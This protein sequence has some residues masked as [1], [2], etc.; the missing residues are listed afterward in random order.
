MSDLDRIRTL[1][2]EL[3]VLVSE[4]FEG[5]APPHFGCI[6]HVD[7]E[8]WR[9]SLKRLDPNVHREDRARATRFLSKHWR[10]PDLT[11]SGD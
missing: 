8:P 5:D 3:V 6:A 1:V 10:T 2:D 11:Q 4:H 9:L 7:G